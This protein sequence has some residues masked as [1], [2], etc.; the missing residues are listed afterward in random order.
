[1]LLSQ[2][3][4]HPQGS[5]DPFRD[6]LVSHPAQ[7]CQIQPMMQHSRCARTVVQFTG[8]ASGAATRGVAFG[9]VLPCTAMETSWVLNTFLTA[10]H[11]P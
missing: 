2:P 1:M 11:T 7:A 5:D 4:L 10:V 8:G 9:A 6:T 3:Q